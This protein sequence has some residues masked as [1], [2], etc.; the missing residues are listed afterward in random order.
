MSRTAEQARA[1]NKAYYAA[2]KDKAKAYRIAN[3]ERVEDAR[4]QDKYGI[5]A[6]Q[7]DVMLAAQGFK[8]AVCSTAS[9]GG[10]GNWHVD[11]CHTTGRVRGLLCCNC[12]RGL[13]YF[14]DNSEFLTNAIAYLND[15]R[16]A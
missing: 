5:T 9:P 10:Q 14:R 8:C 12:N 7:R 11:H 16:G 15:P 13:G 6:E 4:L 2:N 1:Y 3:K